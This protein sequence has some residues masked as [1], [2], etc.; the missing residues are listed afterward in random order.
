MLHLHMTSLMLLK[1]C[2]SEKRKQ[3][4][5]H[6]H[7]PMHSLQRARSSCCC[8]LGRQCAG[9]PSDPAPPECPHLQ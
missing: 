7:A 5:H 1:E 3:A 9:I 4:S 6:G 8:A 2:I